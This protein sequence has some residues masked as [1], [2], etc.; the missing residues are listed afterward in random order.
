V[1]DAKAALPIPVPPGT[2]ANIGT[3]VLRKAHYHRATVE[4]AG[5]C[6]AE[7]WTYWLIK[8]PRDP[9]IAEQRSVTQACRKQ[10]ILRNLPPGSYTLGVSAGKNESLRWALASN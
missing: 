10:F 9:R 2:P 4:L 5:D 7:E 3:I 1:T 8:L 6:T